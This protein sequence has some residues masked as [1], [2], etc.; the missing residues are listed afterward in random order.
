MSRSG[1]DV[2]DLEALLEE[3]QRIDRALFDP[4]WPVTSR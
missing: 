4:Q 3:R 2:L 1:E